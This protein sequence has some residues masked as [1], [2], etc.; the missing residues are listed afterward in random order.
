MPPHRQ[1]RPRR[2]HPMPGPSRPSLRLA[3]DLHCRQPV[4]CLDLALPTR[5]SHAV[6]SSYDDHHICTYIREGPG[7]AVI[8]R[9]MP[10]N[11]LSGQTCQS[12]TWSVIIDRKE[13][14]YSGEGRYNGQT[15]DDDRTFMRSETDQAHQRTLRGPH[16]LSAVRGPGRESA[17]GVSP[18]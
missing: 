12:A 18:A 13:A 15:G 9:P 6:T 4:R 11:R 7:R 1:T 17:G 10:N 2:R 14:Q 5:P 8:A 16:G 3:P